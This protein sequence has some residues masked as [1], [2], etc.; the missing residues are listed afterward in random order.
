MTAPIQQR[1]DV[2]DDLRGWMSTPHIPLSHPFVSLSPLFPLFP[3]CQVPSSLSPYY[4]PIS[5]TL[6]PT[7]WITL[8]ALGHTTHNNIYKHITTRHERNS[9]HANKNKGGHKCRMVNLTRIAINMVQ[10]SAHHHF[11]E[12][13]PYHCHQFHHDAIVG[14]WTS[15]KSNHL[16]VTHFHVCVSCCL[17]CFICRYRCDG[18]VLCVSPHCSNQCAQA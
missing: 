3:P 7:L 14:T 17:A 1:A 5:P 16:Y 2:P 11:N 8:I 12:S 18:M 6:F 9:T 4:A 13:P 10:P 15:R